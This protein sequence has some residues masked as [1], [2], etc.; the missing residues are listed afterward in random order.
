MICR[1]QEEKCQNIFEFDSWLC[2]QYL[3]SY[4][5]KKSIQNN[6]EHLFQFWNSMFLESD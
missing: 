5:L 4:F 6:I 1:K 2:A 3:F